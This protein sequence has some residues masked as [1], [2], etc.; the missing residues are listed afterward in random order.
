MASYKSIL[1]PHTGQLTLIRA[2][3]AFHLKDSVDTYNNLPVFSN[4]ENDVRITQDTDKMYTWGISSSSGSLSDW[5]EIGSA[6]SVDWS[7]ITNKPSSSTAN[8]DDAVSKRHTQDTDTKLDSGGANEVTA[9][10][11]K[12][13]YT[14]SQVS[15]GNPHSVSKSDVGLGNVDNKSEATIITDVKADS[16]VADAITKKHTQD[17]DTKLDEGGANEV[18]AAQA[19]TGYT[20]SQVSSGNPHSVSKSDVG[21]GNVTNDAQIKKAASST[22]DKLPKWKGTSGDELE[23]SSVTES[24]AADAVSKKHTQNTD[25]GTTE[26]TFQIDSDN[27]G[28]KLKNSSGDLQARNSADNAYADF[29]CKNLS[30]GTNE[31]PVGTLLKGGINFVIDGGGAE[32]TTGIKGDIEVPFDC[33]IT[34]VTLLADQS[35]DIK[36]D[37]W[38]DTYANFPPTNDDT[39]TAA[40]E[41]EISSGTKDQDSTLTSW[42]TSLSEGDI[43]RINVDSI[44]TIT[45][46][47]VAIRVRKR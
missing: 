11:A 7:A 37:I 1:N 45:R 13:G 8:I 39:I 10:Q 2:D 3:S 9:A 36:I 31:A 5:K 24:D 21:L 4:T 14:H 38:K 30:D 29:V 47:T 33:T 41:P 43:L 16:D 19:K 28:P 20:H 44:S 35:G 12:T 18:T 42:T 15:S 26:T 46:C 6:S 17:T 40:N 23:D 27:T 34:A 32:I 25:T 22:D